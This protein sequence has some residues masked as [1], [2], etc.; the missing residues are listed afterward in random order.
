[1]QKEELR[2]YA[3]RVAKDSNATQHQKLDAILA[4]SEDTH[5]TV[6]ELNGRLVEVERIQN[7]VVRHPFHQ[8]TPKTIILGAIGFLSLSLAYIKE[9]RDWII[10]LFI[11]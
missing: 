11:P 5:E 1:M 6:T 3:R 9:S 4:L 10:G 2:D 7:E 8:V